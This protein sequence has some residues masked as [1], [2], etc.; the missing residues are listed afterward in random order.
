MLGWTSLGITKNVDALINGSSIEWSISRVKALHSA[1][2]KVKVMATWQRVLAGVMDYF[3]GIRSLLKRLFVKKVTL[4][5]DSFSHI[6]PW[7][8]LL[9]MEMKILSNYIGEL[10]MWRG[11]WF[12]LDEGGI[13]FSCILKYIGR[14]FINV[15]IMCSKSHMNVSCPHGSH[16]L[17]Q[18]SR[19]LYSNTLVLSY[20]LSLIWHLTD[21]WGSIMF[22]KIFKSPLVQLGRWIVV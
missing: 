11:V 17:M 12:W 7:G 14:I 22:L 6:L 21:S 5:W 15:D 3:G 18:I 8:R 1:L 2:L 9:G 20:K 10:L 4:S 16:S 19:H 13:N